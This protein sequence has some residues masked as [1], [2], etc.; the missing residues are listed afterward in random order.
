MDAWGRVMLICIRRMRRQGVPL[1]RN[2]TVKYIAGIENKKGRNMGQKEQADIGEL[3]TAKR[4]RE[5]SAPTKL[6]MG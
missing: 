4:N 6:K 1:E 5:P 2:R 3:K